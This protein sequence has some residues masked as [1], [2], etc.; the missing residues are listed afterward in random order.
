MTTLDDLNVSLAKYEAEH[1][2]YYVQEQQCAT[3]AA[4]YK[5]TIGA[6]QAQIVSLQNQIAAATQP[7]PAGATDPNHPL[8]SA[9]SLRAM[10][11]RGRTTSTRA[12]STRRYGASTASA[13]IGPPLPTPVFGRRATSVSQQASDGATGQYRAADPLLADA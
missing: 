5:A 11:S 2:A 8:L 7:T 1:D 9:R 3:D 6:L 12:S 4:T 10:C 13:A